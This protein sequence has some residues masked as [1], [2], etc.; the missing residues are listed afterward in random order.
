MATGL[1]AAVTALAVVGA[2]TAVSA[3]PPLFA[4]SARP[5]MTEQDALAA[6]AASDERVEV[7]ELRSETTQVFAEPDG[8]LVAESAAVPQ[9]IRRDDGEWAPVELAL[10]KAADGTLRPRAS[11][12]D[13]RFSGG[14]DGPLVTL[15]RNGKTL[16]L[17]W[18]TD[19]RPPTVDGAAATYDDVLPD[20]DL[21]VRATDT[22]FTHVLVVK[23]PEAAAT[24]EVR[25]VSYRLGGDAEVTSHPAGGLQ[26][27]ADGTPVATAPPATM[28][29]SGRPART[30]LR[31]SAADTAPEPSTPTE[32]GTTATVAP[33][34]TTI[35]DDHL[36]LR[37]DPALLA[38]PAAAFPLYVDPS[39]STT[40]N[41]WAY[42]TNNNTNN[43][44]TSV[45]RVGK[46]PQGG[47]IYR[48]FFN[49][50]TAFLNGKHVESAYVQM[51]LDHSASCTE[52]PTHMFH[53]GAI[54]S[55]PRTK[56]SPSLTT[57]VA[58][59]MSRAPEGP[60]CPPKND[61]TV[62]FR[63]AAVTK[64]LQDTA[65]KNRDNTTV[66]FCAC[67]EKKEA[68]SEDNRWKK[69]FPNKAKLIVEYATRPKAP[70]GLNLSG[71]ACK[72]SGV[73]SIGDAEPTF[74]ATYEDADESSN[75][76]LI[77]TYEY[78]NVNADGTTST[79]T[80]PNS[81]SV[82]AGSVA[83]TAELL[84]LQKNDKFR[85]RTR[86]TD[87]APY[88]LQ[89]PWSPWCTFTVDTDVPA[90]PTITVVTEP[91]LPGSL[92]RVTL[93]SKNPDVASFTYGW[94]D[95][96]LLKVNATGTTVKTATVSLTAPRYG[97]L[98]V[99]AYATDITGNKGSNASKKFNVVRPSEAI[100][101]WRL[102]TYPGAELA[103]ALAD[104]KPAVG[105]DTPLAWDP[106]TPDTGWG[107]N[108]RMIGGSTASF[109]RTTGGD[110][111]GAKALVP[112][113]DTSKSF[114][115]AAWARTRD[116][117]VTQTVVSKEG[118]VTSVF[119]LQYRSTEK[120]WCMTMRAR[121]VAGSAVLNVCAPAASFTVGR[122]T[123]LAGLYDD[124]ESR[125][126]LY[127]D[128]ALA[129]NVV[130]S[131]A[132]RN[133]WAGGWN[134]S[135]PVAV[136]RA[137]ETV[138]TPRFVNFFR[139]E[140]ADVQLFNRSLVDVDLVGQRADDANSNGFDEPGIVAPIRVGRWDF[141]TAK[142]CSALGE[143]DTCVTPD[144]SGWSR[145]LGLTPGTA[146]GDGVQD[147]ALE[148]D[149]THFLLPDDPRYTAKTEEY[150][151]SAP[152]TDSTIG[153]PVLRTDQ[154]FTVSAWVRLDDTSTTQT[155]V[156]H[157]TA[158][159][160]YSGFDVVFRASDK[161][162][163]FI[164]R[165]GPA[166]ADVTQRTSVGDIADDPT[167]WHHLVAVSDPGRKQIRL[168]VDGKR[169]AAGPA[170]GGAP[171]QATGP[172]VV[173]RSDQPAGFS[174]W[175]GGSID[176]VNAWQGVLTDSSI[177]LLFMAESATAT[178]AK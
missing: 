57:W 23:T 153:T 76:T 13:V 140:I 49:F 88:N 107:G 159:A 178:P 177:R 28:W 1:T 74:A 83:T 84:G 20:V 143:P 24:A 102:E 149:S 161:R 113:F 89:G 31:A 118:V 18:P 51:E 142:W 119:Q 62:N 106:A 52:S 5:S 136:G 56:W 151:F 61:A 130:A 9:R 45:A 173:G 3:A 82:P 165:N 66:G 46:D 43:G 75:Q 158:G 126:K 40:R 117:S 174:D 65:S 97:G 132:F 87:P 86:A 10:E 7:V 139:G 60:G 39:W 95:L 164:M 55:T 115:V 12:A 29:D 2:A 69:F 53:S 35:V 105:G 121:D 81:R 92:T 128:G 33:V 91:T 100:A 104:A 131:V 145:P 4:Q 116:A 103:T 114:S 64:L 175:L 27:I 19:L 154:P 167:D 90:P 67:N 73:L 70:T 77:A 155:V 135:G 141:D 101:R 120:S 112:A 137:S 98:T 79:R 110:G 85:I 94:D 54:A 169:V 168:Y 96:P 150:G 160:G 58:S 47:R 163:V 21:V 171:W 11:V 123:H 17:S 93:T 111:G 152:A 166:V 37:P 109:D 36:V 125:I 59:T 71:V 138:S 41:K 32:P 6:A 26:A 99:H 108:A 80:P 44:D 15:V 122:W 25:Q 30:G 134:A 129:V 50:P 34:A 63:G 172:L 157:D 148:F 127:V 68:E 176:N 8:R 133:E 156:S 22:G 124:N 170:H 146:G 48:S 78:Q 72:A 38:A 42:S 14:G 147:L 162:W 144:R 16:T